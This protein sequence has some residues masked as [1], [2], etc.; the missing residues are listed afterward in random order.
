[1]SPKL[2]FL[3]VFIV[4]S[5]LSGPV[6][7]QEFSQYGNPLTTLTVKD[8]PVQVEV[9]STRK[10][11]YLGLSHRKEL[12]EGRGMLFVMGS[13]R[14]HPFCMRDMRFSID[15]IWI[16]DGKVAGLHKQLSPSYQGNFRPPVPVPLVLEVPGGFADRHGFK[17]GDPV[18]LPGPGFEEKP[19]R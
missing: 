12:P 18:V 8:A 17:V 4:T 2:L 1:M 7:G 3:I 10:K 16:A 14:R 5:L 19:S 6:R 13:T 9:V 15:V 11:L